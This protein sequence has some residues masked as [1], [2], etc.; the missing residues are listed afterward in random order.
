MIDLPWPSRI[1]SPN[2][3]AHWSGIARAKR[4]ARNQAGWLAR[5]AYGDTFKGCD[6]VTVS[7]TYC[8]PDNRRRDADNIVASLKAALDGVADGI[9]VDDSRFVLR[10]AKGA[11]SDGGRVL[12][13]VSA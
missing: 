12:V 6:S 13:E 8:P 7:I 10:I 1:L 3:R 4:T 2:C 11:V 5:A 9:G